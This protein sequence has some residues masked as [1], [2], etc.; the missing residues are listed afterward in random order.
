VGIA[1]KGNGVI[2]G[3]REVKQKEFIWKGGE[4]RIEKMNQTISKLK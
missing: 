2:G 1:Q 3:A 4:L